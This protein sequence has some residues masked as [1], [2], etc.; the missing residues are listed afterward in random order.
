MIISKP[1]CDWVTALLSSA[2]QIK[3]K[4]ISQPASFRARAPSLSPLHTT[5]IPRVPRSLLT[6]KNHLLKCSTREHLRTLDPYLDFCH[7]HL[8]NTSLVSGSHINDPFLR[9]TCPETSVLVRPHCPLPRSAGFQLQF[10]MHFYAVLIN[11]SFCHSSVCSVVD[12]FCLLFAHQFLL[13][14]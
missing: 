13:S 4:A 14:T 2:F 12:Q 8:P 1:E 9:N 10:A 7:L 11:A 5:S 3:P 6:S